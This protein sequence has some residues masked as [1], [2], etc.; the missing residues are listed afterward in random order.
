[1]PA[2]CEEAVIAGELFRFDRE[3]LSGYLGE[4]FD[5]A[6]AARHWLEGLL[7]HPFG[8]YILS[9]RFPDA[10][11]TSPYALSALLRTAAG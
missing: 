8:A 6:K 3:G 5:R 1:M 7:L 4:G 9:D 11:P 10:L 2:V